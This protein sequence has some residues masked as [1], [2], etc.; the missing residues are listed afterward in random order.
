MISVSHGARRLGSAT[1][2]TTG[3]CLTRCEA[4]V[5]VANSVPA[6]T[7]FADLA[8]Q[9]PG[10]GA[11]AGLI[12]RLFTANSTPLHSRRRQLGSELGRTVP[13]KTAE[14][15]NQHVDLRSARQRQESPRR[16]CAERLISLGY[17]LCWLLT[18]KVIIRVSVFA[19]CCGDSGR[20][21]LTEPAA[22][23]RPIFPAIH[24]RCS[25]LSPMHPDARQWLGGARRSRRRIA[26]SGVDSRIGSWLTKRKRTLWICA[27]PPCLVAMRKPGNGECL[28]THKPELID[29]ASI[30]RMDA[31]V[32]VGPM[33]ADDLLTFE[34]LAE[35]SG[36]D[37]EAIKRD[38]ALV[39]RGDAY[40]AQPLHAVNPDPSTSLPGSPNTTDIGTVTPTEPSPPI[41]ASTSM[42]PDRVVAV[43]EPVEFRDLLDTV[44]HQS[45][46]PSRAAE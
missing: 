28:A 14:F 17:C 27:N 44:P 10:A 19:W 24:E 11:L 32:A 39:Q 15:S 34:L 30:S 13:R 36:K 45:I 12:D 20:Q 2:K 6:L 7:T 41:M 9:E 40:L 1:R 42:V 21:W 46:T 35:V 38:G 25:D 29:Q 3:H 18:Q 37:V 33:Q 8:V 5:A 26:S 16:L 23:G 4:G 22:S 43:A 31:V